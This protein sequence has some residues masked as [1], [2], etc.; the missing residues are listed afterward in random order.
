M[1]GNDTDEF[2]IRF[3]IHRRRFDFRQPRAIG[4]LIQD[5]GTRVGFDFDLESF[6]APTK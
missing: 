5:R 3:A 2:L 4:L 6:Q 1:R